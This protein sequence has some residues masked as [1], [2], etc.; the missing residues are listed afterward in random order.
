MRIVTTSAGPARDLGAAIGPAIM[1]VAI[2]I[3]LTAAVVYGY[4]LRSREPTPTR[5]P[6]PRRG[7]WQTPQERESTEPPDHSKGDPKPQAVGSENASCD[8]EAVPQ[9]GRRRT[10]HQLRHYRGPRT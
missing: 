8:P 9:D 3:I 1:G 2:V 4:R 6:Q 7:A 5:D 10:P